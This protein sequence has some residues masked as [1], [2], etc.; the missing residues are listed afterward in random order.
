MNYLGGGGGGCS[1]VMKRR[2]REGGGHAANMYPI[3]AT[4][5]ARYTEGEEEEGDDKGRDEE[6]KLTK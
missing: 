5:I 6:K 3:I 4:L 2:G 1:G